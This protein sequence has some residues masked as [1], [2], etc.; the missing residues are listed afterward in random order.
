MDS[1]RP[2][3]QA[4]FLMGEKMSVSFGRLV[5][6]FDLEFHIRTG[7]IFGLIGPN[8]AG[9]TT[10][11]NAITGSVPLSGG[12]IHFDGM[13]ISGLKPSSDC[14]TGN[15]AG[16][17]GGHDFPGV[18]GLGPCDDRSP[19]P[20]IDLG[21]GGPFAKPISAGKRRGVAGSGWRPC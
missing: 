18:T 19:L 14:R 16:L 4:P 20:D 1:V 17:S 10:V 3:N 21:L 11:F 13:A 2:E 5:A 8:G 6:V 9:K 7:E 12:K 15:C